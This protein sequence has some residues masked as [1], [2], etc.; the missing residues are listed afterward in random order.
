MKV[1]CILLLSV[2]AAMQVIAT[3]SGSPPITSAST[4]TS[5]EDRSFKRAIESGIVDTSN[6]NLGQHVEVKMRQP[7]PPKESKGKPAAGK[8]TPAAGKPT[9]EKPAAEK[10]T[11]GKPAAGKDKPAAGK[12]TAA[13]KDK[14]AA[15]VKP[16]GCKKTIIKLPAKSTGGQKGTG[17]GGRKAKGSKRSYIDF[18]MPRDA[19]GTPTSFQ[20][21]VARSDA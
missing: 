10:P 11:A 1:S 9:T 15:G 21:H 13:G 4:N 14:P 6:S 5:V 3:P 12:G 7:K 8:G 17:T 20:T 2:S 18:L 19:A 16:R